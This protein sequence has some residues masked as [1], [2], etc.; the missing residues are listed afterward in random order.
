MGMLTTVMPAAAAT[1][2]ARSGR[3]VPTTD[4]QVTFTVD[5]TTT[6]GTVHVP[7]HRSG[8]HLAATLL[9]PGSGPTDR[10]GDQPPTY[11]PHTL[12]LLAKHLGEHGVMSL[13]FD[14]Y[15]SGRTGA[16]AYTGHP[17]DIDMAAFVRQTDT[18]YRELHDQPEA[19]PHALLIVGHSE[20]GLTAMLTA[21]TVDTPPAG[22]ALLEPQDLRILDLV[23]IQLG[24]QL[25]TAVAT[26]KIDPPTARQNKQGIHR[27]IREFRAGKPLDTAG[28][29]PGVA[30][31]FTKVLF[32][33]VN[34][35]FTRSD[36][37][38]YP[39]S[40]AAGLPGHPK[41]LVTCGTADTNVPCT[42]TPPLLLGLMRAGTAGPGLRVLPG[43]DHNL[44]PKGTPPN[45]R[46]LAHPAKDA[47]D[48]FLR[49]WSR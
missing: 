5:G 43:V 19:N 36:D 31:L 3:L 44:H 4:R 33:P 12:A 35:N 26:G 16:G 6:Y 14:K 42:T 13:R 45:T 10:N 28:L 40:V 27:V 17:G 38:I 11:T 22:L 32:S 7:A 2:T 41:I 29:L 15:F 20:G 30:G 48:A 24:E 9:L 21:R 8:E 34:A 25:D 1:T 18:A 46:M 49:P 47:L 23:R 37:A 39:P